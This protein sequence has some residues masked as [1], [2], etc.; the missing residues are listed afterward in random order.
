MIFYFEKNLSQKQEPQC[1]LS[2]AASLI[3]EENLN[4]FFPHP[5]CLHLIKEHFFKISKLS[6][7]KCF[8]SLESK[9]GLW[10]SLETRKRRA[11][12]ST[13]KVKSR[14][15]CKSQKKFARE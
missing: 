11:E 2:A 9:C 5:E 8:P 15:I 12:N 3:A 14:N 4:V 1:Y 7:I 13:N 6:Q 10:L